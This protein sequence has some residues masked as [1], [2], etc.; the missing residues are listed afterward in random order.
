MPLRS[1][2]VVWGTSRDDHFFFTNG[3]LISN[4][5]VGITAISFIPLRKKA[6]VSKPQSP[7]ISNRSQH[8]FLDFISF[9]RYNLVWEIKMASCICL[10]VSWASVFF[11]A[12]STASLEESRGFQSAFWMANLLKGEF[13]MRNRNVEF[14]ELSAPVVTIRMTSIYMIGTNFEVWDYLQHSIAWEFPPQLH[15]PGAFESGD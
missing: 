14:C 2:R 11:L 5:H 15:V 4:G 1:V 10:T 7:P 13:K 8:L 9:C 3:L 12:V 6:L